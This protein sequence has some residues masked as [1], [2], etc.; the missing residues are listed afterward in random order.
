MTKKRK[1][2]ENTLL[3]IILKAIVVHTARKE[4]LKDP[5]FRAII[6]KHGSELKQIAADIQQDLDTIDKLNK[7]GVF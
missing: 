1:L 6:N 3:D 5:E 7:K 2:N 4:G